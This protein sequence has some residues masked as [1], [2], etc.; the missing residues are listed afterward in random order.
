[1]L[2]P[3]L[4]LAVIPLGETLTPIT[5]MPEE[6]RPER[7]D[8]ITWSP[9]GSRVALTGVVDDETVPMWTDD[10]GWHQA[11][12]FDYINKPVFSDDSAHVAFSAGK[13]VSKKKETWSVLLD[14]KS[15]GKEDWIGPVAFLPGTDTP[16]YWTQPGAKLDRNGAYSG[17]AYVLRV[18]KKKGKKWKGMGSLLSLSFARD[19][20]VVGSL[21]PDG[22][23]WTVLLATKKK[24]KNEER[25]VNFSSGLTL[26]A[27]GKAWAFGELVM[28]VTSDPA[29]W[30]PPGIPPSRWNVRRGEE[31]VGMEFQSADMPVFAPTGERLAFRV[32]GKDG[33]GVVIEGVPA[34]AIDHDYVSKIVW[35]EP[36]NGVAAGDEGLAFI[37]I[38]TDEDLGASPVRGISAPI[39]GKFSVVTLDGVGALKKGGQPFDGIADLV[40]ATG[41]ATRRNLAYRARDGFDWILVHEWLDDEGLHMS[42]SKPYRAVGAPVFTPTGVAAGVYKDG[43]FSWLELTR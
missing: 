17:G 4:A 22:T 12:A 9:D 5:T 30:D 25:L 29:T 16:V 14:G 26:S 3:T 10:E 39:E 19:G 24:Q 2:M 27:D 38:A 13:A 37:A 18:G 11:K 36:G 28:D 15:L 1:M 20:S 23:G 21:A 35:E 40:I 31:A 43:E 6:V 42:R 34:A 7:T 41:G 8:W 33:M 32:M